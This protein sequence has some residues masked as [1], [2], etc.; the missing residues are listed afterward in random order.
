MVS[1]LIRRG[2]DINSR[3]KNGWTPLMVACFEGHKDVVK[4]FWKEVRTQISRISG[5]APHELS[6]LSKVIAKSQIFADARKNASHCGF[7]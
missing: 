4:Y 2:A 6:L 3:D 5:V 7:S 1:E